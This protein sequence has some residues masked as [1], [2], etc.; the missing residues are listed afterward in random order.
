LSNLTFSVGTLSPSFNQNTYVYT[1]TL[2]S[3]ASSFTVTTDAFDG[4]ATILVGE[5]T[6]ADGGT[7]QPINWEPGGQ[8]IDIVVTSADGLHS[9]TYTLVLDWPLPAAALS[10]LELSMGSL[11][12]AFHFAQTNQFVTQPSWIQT[13]TVTPTTADPGA[14][15]QINSLPATSGVPSSPI[16]A[17]ATQQ[18]ITIDVTS[19]DGLTNM[20]YLLFVNW[21]S[22]TSDYLKA[23]NTEAVDQFGFSVAIDGDRMVV[24]ATTEDSNA[25]SVNGNEADNSASISGAAYVFS[26]DG[27]SWV[28]EAYLKAS[29][30]E[31]GDQFGFSVAIDG[32]RIVV[33]ANRES[34][35]AT[36]VN[37]NEADNSANASGAAYVFT[38]DGTSWVQ[39]AYLKASNTNGADLFGRAVSISGNRIVVGASGEDSAATGV[40][41]NDANNSA[42]N[43]GAA[44]VFHFDGSD[45]TQ[46]A[47]LKASNTGAHDWFGW[48]VAISGERI[49]VGA[50]DEESAA[51]GVN[52][53]Q[54]DNSATNSGAAYVFHFDGSAWT[55]EAYLKA[56]NTNGADFFGRTLSISGDRI[57]VGAL[58]ED[59]NATG[60]NGN[61]ANNSASDSGAAYV[62][63]FDGSAWTQEAY[64]KAS[65]TEGTDQFGCSVSI[66]GERIVVGALEEDSNSTGVNGSEAD[67]SA[68][69]SG[70]AYVFTFDGTSWVQEAYLKASNTNGADLFGRAVSISG[71]RIAVG[72]TGEASAAT[73]VNG[74]E[75][76]N[77]ATSS[78]AVYIY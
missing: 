56:S 53:D 71:N 8:I 69:N 63:R 36:G 72:A 78:G 77:T 37:G 11:E 39:E 49:V 43:S 76:D 14:T 41:G 18:I 62:F 44:Y 70:A 38:F 25:T 34:S 31:G 22:V 46:E 23:S 28:Q 61:A 12:P 35:N 65:N 6:V 52:G 24:G 33:G 19:A 27:T 42:T 50:S 20:T 64:L 67:N 30:A 73:G 9:N 15:L 1:L 26:F 4:G 51:T 57:V 66:S 32:D 29:N 7:S 59:S 17:Q 48:S 40:D 16:A 21:T 5:E 13:F 10:N 75:A 54:A 74:N 2:T 68:T 58:E 55:Q 60:V 47:Y 45:W 3:T